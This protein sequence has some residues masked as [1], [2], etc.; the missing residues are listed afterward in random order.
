RVLP[1]ITMP[2]GVVSWWRAENNALDSIGTNNGTLSN[3]V[4]FAA[5][6]VGQAFLFNNTN[7]EVK[8]FASPSLNV[9]A[10]NGLSLEMWIKPSDAVNPRPLAEWNDGTNYGTHFWINVANG[11][12][13]SLYAN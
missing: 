10:G 8:V 12:P 4:S 1:I 5:G 6:E 3:G 13:G 11:G 2:A 7:Q 9:G